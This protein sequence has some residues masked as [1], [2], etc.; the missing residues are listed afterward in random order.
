M[1]CSIRSGWCAEAISKKEEPEPPQHQNFIVNEPKRVQISRILKKNLASEDEVYN[2]DELSTRD[3]ALVEK[4]SQK[5]GL[6][7]TF[8]GRGIR[9]K[10]FVHKTKKEVDTTRM[11]GSLPHVTFPEE[12]NQWKCRI[13]RRWSI[14]SIKTHCWWINKDRDFPDIRI[15]FSIKGWRFHW[16]RIPMEYFMLFIC[17]TWKYDMG[18]IF[19]FKK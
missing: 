16:L 6:S 13:K 11:L 9:K 4:L 17:F 1:F 15:F 3:R 10:S 18:Y 14:P 19:F 8:S 12:S 5:M 2:F 7:C